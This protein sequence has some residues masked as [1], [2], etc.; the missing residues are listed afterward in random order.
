MNN[1]NFKIVTIKHEKLGG[2]KAIKKK[3]NSY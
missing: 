3:K 1:Y 2:E